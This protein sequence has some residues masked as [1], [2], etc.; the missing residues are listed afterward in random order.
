MRRSLFR[1]SLAMLLLACPRLVSAAPPTDSPSEPSLVPPPTE[2]SETP[3]SPP[4]SE[5][6]PSGDV[7]SDVGPTGDTTSEQPTSAQPTSAQPTSAPVDR[8]P[9][10]SDAAL[11]DSGDARPTAP[12]NP[13]PLLEAKGNIGPKQMPASVSVYGM[14]MTNVVYDSGTVVPTA[15]SPV[16]AQVGSRVGEGLPT[17]GLFLISA[18]QSRLGVKASVQLTDKLDIQGMLEVDFFG[19]HENTGP[20]GV[21]QP[22]L[23]LR[24]GKLELGSKRFRFIAGQDWSVMTPRL[25]TSLSHSIVAPHTQSGAV[26]GR[27]PQVTFLLRQPIK[28]GQKLGNPRFQLAVSIVRNFSGDGFGGG[29]TRFDLPD[30]GT[31]SRLPAAQA[32]IAFES[33]M[34]SIGAAGHIGR[35]TH[36]V[37]RLDADGNL[38]TIDDNEPNWLVTGDV[39]LKTKWVWLLG[40]GYYGVNANGMLAG[41]GV[42]HDVWTAELVDP[43]DPRLGKDRN[44][45]ALPGGGG[46]A[47]FGALLGTKKVQAFV[48]AGVDKGYLDK[49][50]VGGRWLNFGVLAGILYA[51]FEVFDM[52][53][54]FQRIASHYRAAS[55]DAPRA[56]KL[57]INEFLALSFR[58]KF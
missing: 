52:S 40:E 15:E 51:P 41:Q 38:K 36:P 18:R 50:A 37:A 19:L 2:G 1:A 58:F 48:S 55:E 17:D 3:A 23:R 25:P 44:V 12:P 33:D 24:L 46:W 6:E 57:G 53:L 29:V 30:P 13:N 31:L 26:W 16:I 9:T 54:E 43:A 27:L 34:L 22:G 42:R 11:A 21:I 10:K 5:D 8:P 45:T 14:V 35:E 32:R 28:G 20:A 56:Q 49:V 47:E 4:T 7:D 39:Q